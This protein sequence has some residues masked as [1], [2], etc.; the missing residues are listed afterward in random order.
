MEHQ[1]PSQLNAIYDQMRRLV[2]EF[3]FQVGLPRAAD[4]L[5]LLPG[6]AGAPRR[7]LPIHRNP[8]GLSPAGLAQISVILH[9]NEHH[10]YGRI[11]H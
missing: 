8:S 4:Q 11:A 3:L 7:L 9:S 1:N 2:L 5:D 6:A 10:L